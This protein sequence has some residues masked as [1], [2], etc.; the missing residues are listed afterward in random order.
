M[1]I[2]SVWLY[3]VDGTWDLAREISRGLESAGV[4]THEWSG[5]CEDVPGILV[6]VDV[7]PALLELMTMASDGGRQLLLAV[8]AGAAG[9]ESIRCG[10]GWRLLEAGASDVLVYRDLPQT[11]SDLR[12]RLKRW[13]E[14]ESVVAQPLVQERCVGAGRLWS[15]M[16]RRIAEAALQRSAPILLTGESGTGKEVVAKLIHELDPR[17]DKR[18][19]VIVDCTTI[20][21]ELSGSEFFGHVRGAFTGAHS[22]REGAFALADRGTLFL[23]EVGELPMPL[24]AELLRVVQEGT[25]KAVGSNVWRQT[26]FRLIVA[27]H[28]DLARDVA[29]GRFRHD[30]YH[31]LAGWRI[32]LPPLRQRPEDIPVLARYFL[33]EFALGACAPALAPE[34]TE[35][36]V[37]HSFPGNVRQLRNLLL[38]AMLRYAGSGPITLG[39]IAPEDRPAVSD[40]EQQ[41]PGWLHELESAAE[42]AVACG[43]SLREIGRFAGDCA[44]RLAV[45]AEGGNLQRA[46]KRLGV[47]DRALQ[48][49]I[50][51]KRSNRSGASVRPDEDS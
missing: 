35:F 39:M 16:L 22:D 46:A 10:K 31:R 33:T 1:A 40:L 30:L 44:V 5:R 7:T 36:L 51:S 24:Q 43:A 4:L 20:V 45:G 32:A 49:R 41:G 11:I 48:M 3:S 12:S 14:I 17:P 50:A 34:V 21:R 27:T 29:D 19:L 47:T 8:T 2:G 42:R 26:N 37:A 6:F 13:A 9:P 25:F 18:D 28:R 23:D 15:R 38:R